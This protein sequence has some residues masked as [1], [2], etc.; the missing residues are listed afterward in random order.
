MTHYKIVLSLQLHFQD[1]TGHLS[2]FISS[3]NS[4][5]KEFV[6]KRDHVVELLDKCDT[7]YWGACQKYRSSLTE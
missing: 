3:V 2:S 6:A 7:S 1:S 4:S 5:L